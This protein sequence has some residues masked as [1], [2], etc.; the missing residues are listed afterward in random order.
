MIEKFAGIRG[1]VRSEFLDVPYDCEVRS[2]TQRR[3]QA[4]FEIGTLEG[5]SLWM[6]TLP[7]KTRST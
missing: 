3:T 2:R 1:L 5:D 7:R 4:N 6:P